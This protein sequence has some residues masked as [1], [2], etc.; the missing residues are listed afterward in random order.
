MLERN[1]I[2]AKLG[3]KP[4][5]HMEIAGYRNLRRALS[6]S[7]KIKVPATVIIDDATNQTDDEDRYLIP[8]IHR[9]G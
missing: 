6:L 9:R 2:E 3:F 5:P 4:H 8:I 7:R 1:G